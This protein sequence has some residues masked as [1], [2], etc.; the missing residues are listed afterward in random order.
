MLAGKGGRGE[1]V[2]SFE[3]EADKRGGTGGEVLSSALDADKKG[4]PGRTGKS[5]SG[6]SLVFG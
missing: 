4:E 5:L 2:L 6:L 3:L 1:E